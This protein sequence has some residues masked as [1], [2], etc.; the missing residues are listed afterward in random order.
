VSTPPE[1]LEQ[2]AS[3][4]ESRAAAVPEYGGMHGIEGVMAWQDWLDLFMEP[5]D[6]APVL[7]R[8]LRGTAASL[9]DQPADTV[10]HQH[11]IDFARYIL[12]Q[13]QIKTDPR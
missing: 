5:D 13:R 2:A 10:R 11:A 4:I 1:L 6:L 7:V 8:W 9:R 3:R 12:E